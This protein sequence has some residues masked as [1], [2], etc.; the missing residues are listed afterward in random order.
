M[1]ELTCRC[2]MYAGRVRDGHR[3]LLI[4]VNCPMAPGKLTAVK[5]DGTCRNF[6]PRRKR[7]GRR[8]RPQPADDEIRY[9]ALTKD[10]FAIV[11]RS[12]YKRLSRQRW[13]ASLCNRRYYATRR[14][15][16][17]GT[18][19]MH[20]EIMNPPKGMVVDHIDANGMNNWPGNLRVCTQL[21]NAHGTRPRGLTSRFKGVSYVLELGLWEASI[22]N[23]RK[24]VHIGYYKTEIEAAR[25]YDAEA[26]KRF[27]QF[28]WLNFPHEARRQ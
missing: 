6:H 16:S 21:E 18:M 11:G 17:Q 28:A 24:M 13:Y 12:D 25:A 8:K 1:E 27:G 23:R 3:S 10:R 4:R 14:T 19:Y 2:C 15:R 26:L 9:I 20:R 5:P 22:C 7:S